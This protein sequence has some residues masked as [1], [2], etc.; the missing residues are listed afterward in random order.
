MRNHQIDG[1]RVVDILLGGY[2][3]IS[4]PVAKLLD[5]LYSGSSLSYQE[6][7]VDILDRREKMSRNQSISLVQV[8]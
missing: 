4:V 5:T 1:I 6:Q 7:L 3:L 2:G 8:I